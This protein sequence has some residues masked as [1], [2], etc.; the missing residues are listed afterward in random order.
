MPIK[1]QLFMLSKLY[2]DFRAPRVRFEIPKELSS[3]ELKQYYFIFQENSV[4][5]K[6]Q[7]LIS[8]L[9]ENGIP[10]NRTYIDVVDQDHVYFPI[11]I[12][13]MGLAVFHTYLE[14]GAESDKERFL[15]F[16]DWFVDN[17]LIEPKLGARWMTEVALPQYK[18]PGPWQSAFSQSRAISILL[19]GYQL[20]GNLRYAELAE[21]ALLSFEY[22][23]KEGGV[24]TQT[25]FG[26]FYEEY[27]ASVPT[28][29]MN[30]LI[31]A[32]FGI[33]DF[34]RVFPDNRTADK[35]FSS[36]ISTLEKILPEYDLGF[37]SKY[38]LC[39]A[40]WY[41]EIDPATIRYQRLH[42]EQLQVLYKITKSAVFDKY[43]RK[44][45]KQDSL[46]SA[47]K[48]YRLKYKALKKIGRL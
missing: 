36:G 42:V 44:F 14:S 6:D 9:D 45:R 12:G 28:L 29:V 31:F 37:W 4:A 1:K 20:T 8:R 3:Q 17:A 5:K 11:S 33:Y 30:G 24:T 38:N 16:A 27:A 43:S 35:L 7:R 40:E 18:N 13:Q 21:L 2:Q 23:V 41:P 25:K 47:L 15:K 48:M 32:L 39:K 46:F 19:R 26:P 22:D 10:V 34:K